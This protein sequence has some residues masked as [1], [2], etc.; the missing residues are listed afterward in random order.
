MADIEVSR[1]LLNKNFSVFLVIPRS[2]N[3][4]RIK[5]K[6]S[7]FRTTSLPVKQASLISSLIYA[8]ILTFYL[9]IRI[10]LLNPDFVMATPDASIISYLP[11]APL[12]KIKHV[13]V[14]LDV[15]TIPVETV[16]FS[17]F[18]QC[19]WF[20]ISLLVAK[21]LFNG[22]TVITHLM[23][24]D[25]CKRYGINPLD[26]GVWTSGVS[27]SLFK[28]LENDSEIQEMREKYGL[29][30]KFII[31]Y[32]GVFTPS[33]GLQESVE[34]LEILRKS[35]YSNVVL[36]LLGK[37]SALPLLEDTI[38]Q[39]NLTDNVVI[40]GQVE[41]ENVPKFIQMADVCIVPLPDNPYWRSQSPLKLLEYMSMEKTIILTNIPAHKSVIGDCECGVYLSAVT[42][43]E[44]ANKVKYILE[45]KDKLIEWGKSGRQIVYKNYT[46]EKVANDLITFFLSN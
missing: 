13:K 5:H 41:H 20:T 25:L 19:F 28:P 30:D 45:N 11:M 36:F 32:H 14:V 21:K 33:R 22:I 43:A 39:H 26:V 44:I 1:K 15:R 17:G 10:I 42:P 35:G 29:K 16:G 34:S 31:F 37:G 3:S 46:W 12:L 24:S 8:I 6:S 2:K 9:P 27:E 38:W 40:H 23:K 7:E 4:I 18:L